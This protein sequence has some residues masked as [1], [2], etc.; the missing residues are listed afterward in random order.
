M[1]LSIALFAMLSA[2]L[3][4][5]V[6][7]L[8]M[9]TCEDQANCLVFKT[10]Q[11]STDACIGEDCE[12]EICMTVNFDGTGCSKAGSISHTCE[13]ASDECVG[14]EE[15]WGG[16]SN[17]VYMS[18]GITDGYSSCQTVKAGVTAE[19][20]MKDGSGSCAE[21]GFTFEQTGSG[22]SCQRLEDVY[23]VDGSCTGNVGKECIWTVVAPDS[24][25]PVADEENVNLATASEPVAD[26]ENVDLTT[27]EEEEEYL[28]L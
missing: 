7:A 2:A 19:F 14:S 4:T 25:A 12:F 9:T 22:A 10:T 28:C 13:K 16:F 23:A 11:M 6:H 20:L 27:A 3:T 24:C 17:A 1:N 8:P 15:E 18:E 5:A 21:A 26:E